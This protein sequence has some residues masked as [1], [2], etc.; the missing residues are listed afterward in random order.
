MR[1]RK[2]EIT[3]LQLRAGP[4]NVSGISCCPNSF[5]DT[6]Q[7]AERGRSGPP[8]LASS[9]RLKVVQASDCTGSGRRTRIGHGAPRF[10]LVLFARRVYRPTLRLE[11]IRRS[12]AVASAATETP[13]LRESAEF[14]SSMRSEPG[15][16][17]AVRK[18][19]RTNFGRVRKAWKRATRADGIH[20]I[21]CVNTHGSPEVGRGHNCQR[22]CGGSSNC[23]D[24]KHPLDQ[25]SRRFC[26]W[27]AEARNAPTGDVPEAELAQVSIMCESGA[28]TAVGTPRM[29]PTLVPAM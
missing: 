28:R 18:A 2:P 25:F 1:L 16:R 22:T 27:P 24:S 17:S 19:S 12:A 21:A 26:C 11:D 20:E 8:A 13:M 3:F 15:R 4:A 7:C 9:A 23:R 5:F 10:E 6:R 14:A 29:L